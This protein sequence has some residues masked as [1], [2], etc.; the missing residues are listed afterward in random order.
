MID[1]IIEYNHSMSVV[2][3]ELAENKNPRV[4]ELTALVAA[5][6]LALIFKKDAEEVSKELFEKWEKE[7]K[8]RLMEIK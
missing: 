3:K 1:K 8:S 4:T 7:N 2:A 5:E 6:V